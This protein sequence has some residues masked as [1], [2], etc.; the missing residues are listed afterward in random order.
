MSQ[1][2]LMKQEAAWLSHGA[3]MLC[4][5]KTKECPNKRRTLRRNV[6]THV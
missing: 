5:V 2:L 4:I 1:I 6:G 3:K